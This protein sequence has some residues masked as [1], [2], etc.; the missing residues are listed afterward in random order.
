VRD[1]FQNTD[2]GDAVIKFIMNDF[3]NTTFFNAINLE[4]HKKYLSQFGIAKP[5]VIDTLR[6]FNDNKVKH[7]TIRVD[8]YL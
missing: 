6:I 5:Y 7:C 2:N 4:Q 1:K 3:Y 8:N